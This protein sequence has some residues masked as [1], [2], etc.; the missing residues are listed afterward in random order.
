ML[1]V[2]VSGLS[3]LKNE[4]SKELE[5]NTRTRPNILRVVLGLCA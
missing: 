2:G 4:L 5:G 3:L 1:G